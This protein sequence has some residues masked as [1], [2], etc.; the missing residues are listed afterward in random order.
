[1]GSGHFLVAAVDYLTDRFSQII[2]ELE[3]VPVVDALGRLRDEVQQS[4]E[5][6]GTS[7][8][9]EQ[10]SDANLLKRMVMKRCVYGV[11]L[12]E[13][14]V[15]LA[16]LSL[17]LDA[18]TVGAPLSFLDHHLKHGNS[19]IGAYVGE[20]REELERSGG[21]LGG[22]FA[23]VL[24]RGTELM[25]QVGE[26]PDATEEEVKV[27]ASRFAEA[28]EELGRFRRVLDI[29]TS[30]D[31]GNLGARSF[32]IDEVSSGGAEQLLKGDYDSFA[33]QGRDAT[34]AAID[35]SGAK[36]F[37]HWELEYP[38][39]FYEG[40]KE[41]ENPGFDAVMG[42]PPYVRSI[43]L[44]AAD[45]ESWAYYRASYETTAKGEFDI[46]LNFAELGHEVL[47]QSGRLGFILPNKWITSQVGAGLR[48]LLARER[49]LA[50]LVNFGAAQVFEGVTTYTCLMFLT[51][52]DAERVHVF[53]LARD[54]A[55][56][57]LP[58]APHWAE[59]YVPLS[60][61]GEEPWVLSLGAAGDLLKRL[62]VMESLESVAQ[63]FMGTG[64][65]ADEVF[66]LVGEPSGKV[67]SL[68]SRTLERR[69]ELE[70]EL[71]KP[72]LV[73][74]DIG[75]YAYHEG[76]SLLFPYRTNAVGKVEL[77]PAR[78]L[79]GKYPLTWSYLKENKNALEAR[80]GGRFRGVVGW[81]A[82]GYPRSMHLL[83]TKK[84]VLP[85][86]VNRGRVALD[87]VGRYIVDTAYGLALK[88]GAKISPNF[89]ACV[90][91]S[92]M[93]T[94]FLQETGTDARG[95]Y[96]RIKT[97]YL[98]PFPMISVDFATPEPEREAAVE[99]AKRRYE[100][101]DH[102]AVVR[103]CERELGWAP[104]NGLADDVRNDTVH[105][106]LSHLA[107]EMIAI[108]KKR[109]GV[110]QVWQEWVE[111]VVP[112]QQRLTK[113][114]MEKGWIEAG[115]A[116]GW[117]GV[118]A[119]F[120]ARRAVPDGRTLRDLKAETERALK[121]LHPLYEHIRYTDRLIDNIVYRLYGLTED[122]I[123]VVEGSVGSS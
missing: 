68:Y 7:A 95:G 38:E 114:F 57:P 60:E 55:V 27:S 72:T 12:N 11:D 34:A 83:H 101:G 87:G 30:Q 40:D 65:R 25:Q 93:L 99:E 59:G 98:N 36:H 92:P 58:P 51:R 81:Y 115:L 42:N 112:N 37:F 41:R 47:R 118:L 122:E 35:W 84:L 89:V 117:G 71:V 77:I 63:V 100:A 97:N 78:E 6:Y 62:R 74:R 17:W 119:E 105:D 4:L 54:A 116:A 69:V 70:G 39:V 94:F 79:R 61:L 113:V 50:G 21:L 33:Q 102:V 76:H 120:Q 26:M 108:H 43:S 3:A 15:E 73:G 22:E 103:W 10:L 23:D 80:E 16:K 46:Y 31:F 106:F 67:E 48:G 90:L 5:D 111:A 121:E 19:L 88:G 91:N 2:A 14:A 85:D 13:M 49:S 104:E 28:D 20:I 52:H 75:R 82:Y 45:P 107:E 66:V 96:F 32:L 44:K 86:L 109:D 110:E 123:A 53:A 56:Q 1:M 8:M 29:W 24:V 18:F 9:P 64:T